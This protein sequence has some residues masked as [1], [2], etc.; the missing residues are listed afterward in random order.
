MNE[1]KDK[2]ITTGTINWKRWEEDSTVTISV[3]Y[4]AVSPSTDESCKN[5]M[6]DS[7][8]SRQS[9]HQV[10]PEQK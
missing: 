3:F 2:R 9:S 10:F 6:E 8:Y 1:I 5:S 4:H 7:C